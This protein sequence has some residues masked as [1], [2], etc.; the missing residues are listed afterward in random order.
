LS[1]RTDVPWFR[2]WPRKAEDFRGRNYVV[3]QIPRILTEDSHSYDKVVSQLPGSSV[4]IEWDIVV[5]P[6]MIETFNGHVARAP[7]RVQV[8]PFRLYEGTPRPVWAHRKFNKDGHV[9]W[10]EEGDEVCDLFAIGLVYF[11]A[12]FVSTIPPEHATHD[13]PMGRWLDAPVPIHWD[14][15]PIHLHY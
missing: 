15:R 7:S 2:T 4:V 12:W 5:S 14:V 11:P 6:E 1:S 9:V 8:A 3:D 13:E 10:V